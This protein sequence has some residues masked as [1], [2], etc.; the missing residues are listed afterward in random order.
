RAF[1]GASLPVEYG[2]YGTSL[3]CVAVFVIDAQFVST[4][5]F[6]LRGQFVTCLL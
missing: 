6:V 3:E 1:I 5:V 4:A 2:E